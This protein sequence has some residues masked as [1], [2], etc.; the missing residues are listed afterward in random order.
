M[1]SEDIILY[2]IEY[3]DLPTKTSLYSTCRAYSLLRKPSNQ[4]IIECCVYGY[5][6]LLDYYNYRK[7]PHEHCCRASRFNLDS[8]RHIHSNKPCS[9]IFTIAPTYTDTS[10]LSWLCSCNPTHY[11]IHNMVT[12][13]TQFGNLDALRILEKSTTLNEYV[14]QD[15]IIYDHVNIVEY[16]SKYWSK[17]MCIFAAHKSAYR[18][19]QWA[20]SRDILYVNNL[21]KVAY[22]CGYF[23]L[24]KWLYSNI[25]CSEIDCKLASKYGRLNILKW[26]RSNDCK[27]DSSAYIAA[28][29]E[30]IRNWIADNGGVVVDINTMW[31]LCNF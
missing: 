8:L 1:L 2:I 14:F 22:K 9:S 30:E 4:L 12:M 6:Q 7:C 26:L 10:I 20:H 27:W 29:N 17:K 25:G 24:V 28:S 16:M 23:K 15:A 13:A 5:T 31:I 11:Q 19:L 3:T 18:T 21:R